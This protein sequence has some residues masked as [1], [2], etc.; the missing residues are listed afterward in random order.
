MNNFNFDMS[1]LKNIRPSLLVSYGGAFFAI[2]TALVFVLGLFNVVN[3]VPLIGNILDL[4]AV[5]YLY[6]DR[7]R[8]VPFVVRSAKSA[9]ELAV[10]PS[11]AEAHPETELLLKQ[12]D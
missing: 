9:Y 3:S 1:A 10:T 7:E 4:V 2:T 8:V 12:L 5:Y 6:K 11:E